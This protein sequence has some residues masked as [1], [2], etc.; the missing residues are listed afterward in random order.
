[1]STILSEVGTGNNVGVGDLLQAFIMFVTHHDH[2]LGLL[3][4]VGTLAE[5]ALL[6]ESLGVFLEVIHQQLEQLR[7][8]IVSF[9]LRYG[10]FTYSFISYLG[11]YDFGGCFG[12]S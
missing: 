10:G 11:I 1:M 4:N 5:D 9:V 6:L 3:D 2:D 12:D 8:T 7:Q